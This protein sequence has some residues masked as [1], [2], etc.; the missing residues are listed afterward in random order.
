MEIGEALVQGAPIL[1]GNDGKTR[2]FTESPLSPGKLYSVSPKLP[3]HSSFLNQGGKD[4]FLTGYALKM[5]EAGSANRNFP[6]HFGCRRVSLLCIA[7]QADG[8]LKVKTSRESMMHEVTTLE[9]E[10]MNITRL[11]RIW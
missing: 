10:Y 5:L 3:G 2:L 4:S 7:E 9:G 6:A 1:V 8:T 11:F